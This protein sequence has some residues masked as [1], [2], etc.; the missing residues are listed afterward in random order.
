MKRISAC[1]SLMSLIFLGS[2]LTACSQQKLADFAETKPAFS[3]LEFFEGNSI[4]YGI[5]E[6]RFGTLKRRFKV[7]IAGEVSQQE[8]AGKII[9]QIVLTEDFIYEDGETQQ[10]IWTI[11]KKISEDGNALY[12][13]VASDV[14]SAAEGAESG[15]AF[16]WK[17]DVE[18]EI[19]DNNVK[20]KFTDW[21]YQMDD[22]VAINKATVSKFGVEIGVV[23]LVFIRGA[24]ADVIG[25]FDVL[26]W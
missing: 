19:S 12:Q 11:S 21:I 6:D 2:I 1:F 18:L 22:Y 20:V 26:K 16:F 17:Y 23:T 3:L 7:N 25:P 5:F 24:P 15:S 8:T 9:D 14:T 13:G 10:R 4:A